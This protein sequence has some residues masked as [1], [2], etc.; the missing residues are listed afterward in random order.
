MKRA[1]TLIEL[2]VVIAIIA[3]LAAILFPVFAQA[4]EAAKKTTSLNNVKQLGIGVAMYT[5]DNDDVFPLSMSRRASGTYRWATVHP[6]PA[7]SVTDGGWDSAV[8]IDASNQMWT[9]SMY[10]YLKNGDILRS[11]SQHEVTLAGETF[12]N[13]IKPITVGM[14]FNGLLHAWNASAI[15]MPSVVP[16][17]WTGVGNSALKGRVAANPN[18]QCAGRLD[19][20]FNPG[21]LAQADN[22]A[23]TQSAFFG[24]GTFDAGWNMWTHGGKDGGGA[25]FVRADTSAKYQR[26]ATVQDPQYH[27]TAET[28]PYALWY[29]D[30]DGTTGFAYWATV[31]GDCTDTSDANATG[32]NTYVCYFR[33]DRTK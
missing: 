13:V 29:I 10:P 32:E 20:R 30:T 1:F 26:I 24:Y 27:A 18:L 12:S 19:C 25:L 5:T 14:T 28:D 22:T 4:K 3:I 16:A 11:Q 7:G 21:G 9:A 6:F 17:F 8:A 23:S 33:P 15:E 31:S 2:L